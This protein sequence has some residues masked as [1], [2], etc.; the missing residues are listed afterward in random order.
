MVCFD[1]LRMRMSEL[2]LLTYQSRRIC[3]IFPSD[4]QE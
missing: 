2:P 4:S 1:H 3:E